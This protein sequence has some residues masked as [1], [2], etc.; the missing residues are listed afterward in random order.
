MRR[1][2]AKLKP[3]SGYSPGLL[4]VLNG[5]FAVAIFLLVQLNFTPLAVVSIFL[6]K[7][8]MLAVKPRHWPANIR[9]NLVD[10]TIGLAAISFIQSAHDNVPL[11]LVWAGLYGVWLVVL[12]PLSSK[13]GVIAQALLA[14]FIGLVAFL[15]GYRETSI[16]V[17]M[18]VVWLIC[19]SSARHFLSAFEEN[20]SRPLAYIWAL[21]AVQLTWVLGHWVIF[22]GF[23]PQIALVLSFLG[24]SL[25]AM[26][27]IHKQERLTQ[28][29]MLQFYSVMGLFMLLVLILSDWQDK[30]L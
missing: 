13:W 4:R 16:F 11:Q 3:A 22:Y 21:F 28:N 25:G 19:Y 1:L 12:K 14:Q 23:L 27:Y 24:Y 29:I 5:L 26:Y 15:G 7:W 10:I 9:A 6:S 2:V 18:I 8:R 30:T 17:M 20:L